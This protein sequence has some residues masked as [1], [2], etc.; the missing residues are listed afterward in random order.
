MPWHRISL[1]LDDD[2]TT[3]DMELCDKVDRRLD[4][5]HALAEVYICST[6][7]TRD[8]ADLYFCPR[9]EELCSDILAEYGAVE[10]DKPATR[11]PAF[12]L[13]NPD[14]GKQHWPDQA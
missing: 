11:P 12:V 10:C 13:G 5:R 1:R 7:S 3:R 8:P 4:D 9:A 2:S 6:V 14:L